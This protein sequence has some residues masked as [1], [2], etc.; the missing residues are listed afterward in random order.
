[1][2]IGNAG[3]YNGSTNGPDGCLN[4]GMSGVVYDAGIDIL[5]YGTSE[6]LSVFL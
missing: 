6:H 1:M 2:Y 5:A 4:S 3:R